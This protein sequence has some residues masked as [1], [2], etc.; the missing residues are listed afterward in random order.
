MT[1]R[2]DYKGAV[3][4][5][6]NLDEARQAVAGLVEAGV[7]A[8]A[9][10]FLWSF[11]N[12][13][14]ERA[15]TERLP[16]GILKVIATRRGRILGVTALGPEAAEHVALWGLAMNKRLRLSALAGLAAAYPSRADAAR[17]LAASATQPRLT[18]PWRRRIIRLLG[19]FG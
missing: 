13:S 1:E 2:T 8:I 12:P 18:A 16:E 19:K 10:S 6:P 5:P 4:V 14:H 15:V 11:I 9:I 7:E 17:A 3:I